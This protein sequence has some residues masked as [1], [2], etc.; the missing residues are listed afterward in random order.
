MEGWRGGG[1]EGWRGGG[2]EVW[3]CR[4]VEVWRGGGVEG[5][6]GGGVH[7]VEYD[8]FYSHSIHYRFL[9]PVLDISETL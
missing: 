2:V 3:R 8:Y 5:W 9:L 4:G 1:V 6:R 7:I